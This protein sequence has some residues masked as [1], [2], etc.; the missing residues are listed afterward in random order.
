PALV[1]DLQSGKN[2]SQ[3]FQNQK[4]APR[5][6]R[7]QLM[8]VAGEH[9]LLEVLKNLEDYY[10]AKN[11]KFL[12]MATAL[13]EPLLIGGMGLLVGAL[14]IFVFFPLLQSMQNVSF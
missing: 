1:G 3:A 12:K 9:D 5:F 11:E 10:R 13:L 4:Q 2:F 8:L 14:V 7:Q 6:L